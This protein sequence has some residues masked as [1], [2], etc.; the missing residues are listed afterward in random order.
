MPRRL[1]G[2]ET[3][4]AFS[5]V[6]HEGR[7]LRDRETLLREL[8]AIATRRLEHLPDGSAFGIFLANGSRLYVDAGNHPE[9]STPECTDP[10]EAVRYTKAG[11]RILAR[12]LAELTDKRARSD[13]ARPFLFKSNVD[14][15]GSRSTWGC[16]ESYMHAT[17]HERVLDG[18]VSHLVSRICFT[19]AGGFDSLSRGI[20][21]MISPR[22]AHLSQVISNGSTEPRG[23]THT[24]DEP[25]CNGGHHR[26]H[27]ICGESLCSEQAQVL[28]LGTTALVVALIEGGRREPL[29]LRPC[30]PVKA[31]KRLGKDP[32]CRTRVEL[33][34]GR[35]LT[36]IEIQRCLLDAA[37]RSAGRS[38]MP[39]WTDDLCRLWASALDALEAGAPDSVADRFDW[40]IKHAI[41]EALAARRGVDWTSLPKWSWVLHRLPSEP[42]RT[43]E[44]VDADF[45]Q[46]D[47]F[48]VESAGL[49]RSR[50]MLHVLEESLRARLRAGAQRGCDDD[51]QRA[52]A[53]ARNQ[54]ERLSRYL[55]RRGLA[56]SGLEPVKALR[57]ELFETDLRFAELGDDGVFA[58]L[59]REG[60][61]E[62]ATGGLGDIEVAVAEPPP[63]GRAHLRGMQ[64]RE[65]ARKGGQL[66]CTWDAIFDHEGLRCF[67]MRDPWGENAAWNERRSE[68]DALGSE[69]ERLRAQVRARLERRRAA[70]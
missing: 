34:D 16:H 64:I 69:A 2:L 51:Q 8:F 27:V 29:A 59:D 60:L 57:W 31:M 40:A 17:S 21:F 32:R 54:H 52:E 47:L 37:A 24:K 61:L 48:P 38:F 26:L 14:Y 67:D 18:V 66:S 70:R 65:L 28:K 36:A 22:V 23:I 50:L 20:D 39:S 33:A 41:F 15:S 13:G 5:V 9:L 46:G 10:W 62:H 49:P 3:E 56:W 45:D 4:Y 55:V 68:L 42:D 1:L 58:R 25:L 30:K 44:P 12:L 11:E 43:A 6:D 35:K 7:A 53:E 63:G 19:G